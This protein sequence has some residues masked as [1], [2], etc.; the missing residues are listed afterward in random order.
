MK[1]TRPIILI[2]LL[3]ISLITL[4]SCESLPGMDKLGKQ[5]QSVR[6]QIDVDYGMKPTIHNGKPGVAGPFILTKRDEAQVEPSD[7]HPVPTK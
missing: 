3:L 1:K 6:D 4:P 2:S 7:T 5:A